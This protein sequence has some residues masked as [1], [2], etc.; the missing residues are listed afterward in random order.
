[1]FH[2]LTKGQKRA[3]RAAA[4][5]AH[6]RDR[7]MAWEDRDVHYLEARNSD[8][9]LV[10]GGAVAQ[11]LVAIDEIGEPARALVADLAARIRAVMDVQPSTA[12]PDAGEDDGYDDAAPVSVAAIVREIDSLT[13]ETTLYVNRRTGEA[14][15]MEHEYLPDEGEEEGEVGEEDLDDLPDWQLQARA[16]G[17]EVA[18]NP[19]WIALLDRFDVNDRDIMVRYARRA[20]PAASRD[21]LDALHGRGAYRRFRDEVH[22]RGLQKEWDAFR[23]ESLAE[24]VRDALRERGVA[25]RR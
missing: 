12:R 15:V 4:E 16:E 25:F 8:L 17:R 24:L 20:R 13:D 5:L 3:L 19:D 23:A 1:M 7:K 2:D 18:S 9:P 10:V 11:G 21:L 14:R 22:R 6:G